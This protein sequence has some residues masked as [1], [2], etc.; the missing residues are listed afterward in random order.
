MTTITIADLNSDCT[1]DREAMSFK[2]GGSAPW[3]YGWIAPYSPQTPA[4]GQVVNFYQI[5]NS[6]YANQMINQ[7]QTIDVN[8]SGANSNISLVPVM[9][10]TPQVS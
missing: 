4:F 8:N 7:Y 5:N 6:F 1:L 10:T 3:V 2:K 9:V